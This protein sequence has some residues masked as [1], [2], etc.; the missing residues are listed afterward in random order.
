MRYVIVLLMLAI[1]S[2]CLVWIAPDGKVKANDMRQAVCLN[3][4][5]ERLLAQ[6]AF[7][8]AI[9]A[10]T[11]MKRSC[12][13][14]PYCEGVARFYL[15]QCDLELARFDEAMKQ[16]D[17]AEAIFSRLDKEV[18]KAKVLHV[19][20]RVFS[21]K[22]QYREAL[23]YFDHAR[24]TFLKPETRDDAELF[25][26]LTNRA[27]VNIYLSRFDEAIKD[28]ND[29]EA[30]PVKGSNKNRL[31]VLNER[32]GLLA[33]QQQ[34]FATAVKH[35]HDAM[36]H[37]SRVGNLRGMSAVL[38]NMGHIEE[39]QAHYA[40]ALKKYQRAL[41]LAKRFNDPSSQAFAFNNLGSV[42]WKRGNYEE[43]VRMY[44]QALTIREQLA[45]RMFFGETLNNLG[46]VYLDYGEYD[47]AFQKFQKAYQIAQEN[48]SPAGKAWA[49]HNMA[50][51]FKDK[52][53]LKKAQ[54]FSQQ[55]IQ[56]AEQIRNRRLLATALLRLG[57]LYEY[58]GDF[59][60][61]LAAYARVAR[62]QEE[63][64]DKLFLS[65]TLVDMG[66]I[67][68]RR[69]DVKSA[70]QTYQKALDIQREIGVPQE[71][72]LCKFALFHV[73]KHQYAEADGQPGAD[74]ASDLRLAR[75]YIEQAEATMD[76]EAGNVLMLLTYVKAKLA[77]EHNPTTAKSLFKKL[78]T[79]ANSAGSLKYS[80]LAHVGLGLA[81]E[82]LGKYS[83]AESAYQSAVKYAEGI[84]KTLDPVTRRTFL[85]GEEILGMK[86][87]RPYEGLARVRLLKG[88]KITSL[89]AS[90]FTKARSFADRIA[91]RIPGASFGADRDLIDKL[92]DVESKIRASNQRMEECRE[93]GGDHSQVPK[94]VKE[95][96]DLE[97][98][99]KAL[100]EEIQR[101]Y[102]SFHAVRFPRPV[103]IR[104]ALLRVGEQVLSFEVTDTGIL[105]FLNNG[106]Q[107][108]EALYKPVP[109]RQVDALVRSFRESFEKLTQNNAYEKLGSFDLEAGRK[110]YDVL[111]ADVLSKIDKGKPITIVPDDS[112]TVVPFEMLIANHSGT[113]NVDGDFPV[114]EG[115]EF[116]A[117]RNPISYA[118]SITA[119][120]LTRRFAKKRPT[121]K[122]VLVIAN[123][124]IDA[125]NRLTDDTGYTVAELQI[126]SPNAGESIKTAGAA[127]GESVRKLLSPETYNNLL[128][129]E[130][131]QETEILAKD[132]VKSYG[133]LVDTYTG[134]DATLAVFTEK[135]IP[136][137]GSYDTIV[138]AT[139]GY[140]GHDL[141][142]EILEPILVLSM[143]PPRVDNLL[144]MSSVMNL[145]INADLVTLIAC[146][147]G[148]GKRISG[149]GTMGMGR[150]FQYAGARS[151]LMSLW[152]VDA[153]TS[154][155]LVESMLNHI[156]AGKSKL[157]ALALARQEIRSS[158][159]DHP[160]FWAAF[161]LVG[162][163]E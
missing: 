125:T 148:L 80:F 151:V 117:D 114:V 158:G 163:N 147:T 85:H 137:I 134:Q 63:I 66:N 31:A 86:H 157:E 8:D 52:G 103:K 110:L 64:G 40:E 18:E 93:K 127:E 11:H 152:S 131:L 32:R 141:E 41:E 128:A 23:D 79:D 96:N 1:G 7:S 30:L 37:Y 34:H 45:I 105:I 59:D 133:D 116:L 155:Q 130:P 73:E 122:R 144:R 17:Q 102:P 22:T 126:E 28:L 47:K 145:D 138:F 90:E 3:K 67:L 82:Q 115:A 61:A 108:V 81:N 123:P 55:A 118:H 159:R 35:Y 112:L 153:G 26:V 16:L 91:Q 135:I 14:N 149:E 2:T 25:A 146:Q 20:G 58:Y 9:V 44:E 119:L 95:L 49:L 136:K 5:G 38:T 51:V 19:K 6:S 160:F 53:E 100:E 4:K 56:L 42:H 75:Q 27:K 33:A 62:V 129:F 77:L 15:G 162:E 109:R 24:R 70:E 84:R 104:D 36:A 120:S 156:K 87:V 10:F 48:D 72:L 98:R 92:D 83:Q 111:L 46:I 74:R 142:P 150:A 60:H 78:K 161:V 94:L 65:K 69:G 54:H 89:E 101:K 113:I 121:E 106:T 140:F 143:T 76:P 13:G 71:E 29:A 50:W 132:L 21:N 12:G 68:T 139:H 43:A 88:E 124:I 57:N 107:V 97:A 154:V 99:W 39:T